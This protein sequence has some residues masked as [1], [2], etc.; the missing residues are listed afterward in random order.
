M[1]CTNYLPPSSQAINAKPAK[2]CLTGGAKEK[3]WDILWK[4][5][6]LAAMTWIAEWVISESIRIFCIL[7]DKWLNNNCV[8]FGVTSELKALEFGVRD[9]FA[10]RL[11]WG[12]IQRNQVRQVVEGYLKW[13]KAYSTW[14][15]RLQEVSSVNWRNTNWNIKGLHYSISRYCVT[16]SK[17][18]SIG[19]N[20]V[21]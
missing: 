1:W 15:H 21:H 14:V 5:P 8:R 9:M 4:N 20:A 6:I 13:N 17:H 11:G 18:L 2:L 19:D 12:R 3:Q 7:R 10:R 16:L